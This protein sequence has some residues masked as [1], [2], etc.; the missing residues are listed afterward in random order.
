M[1]ETGKHWKASRLQLG[2]ELAD[3][4][5]LLRLSVDWLS[6]VEAGEWRATATEARRLRELYAMPQVKGGGVC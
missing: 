6:K 1:K 2:L 3:A 5:D 4:A